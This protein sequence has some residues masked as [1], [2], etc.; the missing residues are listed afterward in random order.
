MR[1]MMPQRMKGSQEVFLDVGDPVDLERARR[2]AGQLLAHDRLDLG[3]VLECNDDLF[4]ADLD[5]PDLL[6]GHELL[7]L[8]VADL[9]AAHAQM[10][11]DGKEPDEN[12]EPPKE[13]AA[14]VS[15][16]GQIGSLPPLLSL[17][18]GILGHRFTRTAVP[19]SPGP[20]MPL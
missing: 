13:D 16:L 5:F 18:L 3:L 15:A 10:L 2:L 11:L 14:P 7:E 9:R 17:L 20:G 8:V 19:L 6:L 4:I 1:G 12:H